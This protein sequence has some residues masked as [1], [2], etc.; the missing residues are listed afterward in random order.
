VSRRFAFEPAARETYL[1]LRK[2]PDDLLCIAVRAAL[3]EL[4]EN[5]GSQHVRPVL[6]KP[7]TWGLQVRSGDHRWLVLWRQAEADAD[8]LEVHYL[9]PAPGES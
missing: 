9:D 2:N 7:N 6:Y 8:V 3:T 1:A 4:L 5:P